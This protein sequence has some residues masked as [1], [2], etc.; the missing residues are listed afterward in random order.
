MPDSARAAQRRVVLL[1]A[2]LGFTG[3]T[4][5]LFATARALRAAGADVQIV[6]TDGS[7][8]DAL[9]RDGFEPH[10]IELPREP[11]KEPFAAWR[12]RG[13]LASL[14]PDLVQVTSEPLA[15]LAA[16][17][18]ATLPFPY[19]LEVHRAPRAPIPFA[20]KRLAAVVLS[21][22]TLAASVVNQ[23]LLPRDKLTE[24]LHAP[25]PAE[26]WSAN[27]FGRADPVLVGT[28]GFLDR[29]HGTETFLDAAEH[30]V[31]QASPV[32]FAVLG[33]GP[34][35]RELRRR[36]RRR[37]LAERVTIG[38][39]STLEAAATLR[40][41]DIAV[42]CRQDGGPDWIAHLTLALGVPAIFP[43][44]GPAFDLVRHEVDGVLVPRND[45]AALAQTIADLAETPLVARAI[46]AR[47]RER[48]KS[49][50]PRGSYAAGLAELHERAL[51]VLA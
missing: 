3:A 39:P 19:V 38:V 41:F 6:S 46:G 17:C 20:P 5:R 36:V 51:A 29:I 26:A 2:W 27:P 43:A 9:E 49:E 45:P 21:A 35:E 16:W 1:H 14:A 4:E 8:R 30:L 34:C 23:G 32:H 48:W 13:L 37:G 18:A 25:E 42:T 44:A 50:H 40:R 28:A 47:A 24:L 15:A 22:P 31:A 12:V 7:R 10:L 33:E 11:W